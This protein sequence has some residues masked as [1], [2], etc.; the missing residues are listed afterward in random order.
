MDSL[1]P[2]RAILLILGIICAVIM[3]LLIIFSVVYSYW[4]GY[5]MGPSSRNVAA[6]RNVSTAAVVTGSP[7]RPVSEAAT[8]VVN[9]S[10]PR[11]VSQTPQRPMRAL[12]TRAI[13]GED[14]QGGSSNSSCVICL[15]DFEVGEEVVVLPCS[16]VFHALCVGTWLGT[17]TRCPWCRK[18]V[19]RVDDDVAN[20]VV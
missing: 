11:R 10:P 16:H 9:G 12:P 13:C 1:N 3:G 20:D 7:L 6:A 2:L 19:D 14:L 15:T 4:M 8:A 18:I 17:H 5:C